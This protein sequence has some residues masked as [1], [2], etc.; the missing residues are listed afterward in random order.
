MTQNIFAK[1]LFNCFR[2]FAEPNE[3]YEHFH[4]TVDA[5]CGHH[6]V[7]QA[8]PECNN[9][10]PNNVTPSP[11]KMPPNNSV[12][13]ICID[14]HDLLFGRGGS[15]EHEKGVLGLSA[16]KTGKEFIIHQA[17]QNAASQHD[18]K[19]LTGARLSFNK[20]SGVQEWKS[21]CFLW[22]NLGGKGGSV[23]NQ[24]LDGGRK[25]TWFGG[26]RMHDNSL[27]IQRLL[28]LGTSDPSNPSIVLWCRTYQPAIK[29]FGPYVCFGRL[30]YH[31]HIPGSQPLSFVWNLVDFELLNSS[32]E[33]IVRK[34]FQNAVRGGTG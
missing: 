8:D 29:A 7:S 28:D 20:Y 3:N 30:S 24:F 23:E 9:N 12:R 18:L 2:F 22:I 17:F 32:N 26:S 1:L 13:T 34:T 27:V 19:R 15:N 6:G 25:V 5:Q 21:A 14:I 10:P 4:E 33:E 16:T 11:Q 31:S